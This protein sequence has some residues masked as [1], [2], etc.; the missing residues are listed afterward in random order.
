MNFLK[1]NYAKILWAVGAVVF[2]IIVVFS[3]LFF[4]TK[5]IITYEECVKAGWLVRSVSIYDN[6]DPFPN[7]YECVLWSGKNFEKYEE[8]QEVEIKKP[9]NLTEGQCVIQVLGEKA[10][11]LEE[12]KEKCR[13][14]VVLDK[15]GTI[16]EII[17]K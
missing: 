16:L 7:K 13:I 6:I 17:E 14:L 5:K 2:L 15:D 10:E 12:M 3:I 1:Q 8:K 4:K 9:H 11:L